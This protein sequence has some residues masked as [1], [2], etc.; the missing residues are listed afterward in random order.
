MPGERP[1]LMLFLYISPSADITGPITSN[2]PGT[3]DFKRFDL[4]RLRGTAEAM[5]DLHPTAAVGRRT[6]RARIKF[7]Q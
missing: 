4:V 7:R 2:D 1:S 6:R 3:L 5:A